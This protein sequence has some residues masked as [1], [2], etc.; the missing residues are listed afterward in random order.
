MQ[1]QQYS[2]EARAHVEAAEQ[3]RAA[4]Y[5]DARVDAEA[6]LPQAKEAISALRAARQRSATHLVEEFLFQAVRSGYSRGSFGFGPIVTQFYDQKGKGPF[7]RSVGPQR[8]E[9]I[10][11]WMRREPFEFEVPLLGP[12]TVSRFQT[13]NWS[14]SPIG[15]LD[16]FARGVMYEYFSQPTESGPVV[17]HQVPAARGLREFIK[18][19]E[20]HLVYLPD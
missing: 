17:T 13:M 15:S 20:D 19:V 8:S 14:V 18:E 12:T 11:W 7:R 10:G 5:E 3:E 9:L 4:A 1:R 6:L 2:Q 16:E